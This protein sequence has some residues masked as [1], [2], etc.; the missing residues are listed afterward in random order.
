MK[1]KLFIFALLAA[2]TVAFP[3][4]L[5]S[6]MNIPSG[7]LTKAKKAQIYLNRVLIRYELGR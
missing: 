3:S 6:R 2:L 1:W 5:K 4:T 7:G